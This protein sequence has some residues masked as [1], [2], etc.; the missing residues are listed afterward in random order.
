[1]PSMKLSTARAALAARTR[2]GFCQITL[3][4][5][6]LVAAFELARTPVTGS[7]GVAIDLWRALAVVALFLFFCVPGSH[8]R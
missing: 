8:R 1:M 3:A 6:F 5:L 7:G 2:R 4:L